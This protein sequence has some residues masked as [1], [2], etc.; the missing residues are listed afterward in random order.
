MQ[1]RSV[2][3]ERSGKRTVTSG[4]RCVASVL[5]VCCLCVANVL[6]MCC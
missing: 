1:V 3:L 5:L 4:S 6:L 2:G